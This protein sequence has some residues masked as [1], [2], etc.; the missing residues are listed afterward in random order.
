MTR[1]D[2]KR[3]VRRSFIDIKTTPDAKHDTEQKQR[4]GNADD[5]QQTAPFVAK[6]GFS[7]EGGKSH[8][9]KISYIQQHGAGRRS[10]LSKS[11]VA[12]E[13]SRTGE[14]SREC[15]SQLAP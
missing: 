9:I 8:R 5:G 4:E 11:S 1:H 2:A 6:G 7:D 14:R 15:L 13:V 10:G 3:R 12:V